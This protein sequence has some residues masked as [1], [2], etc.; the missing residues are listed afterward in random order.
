[1]AA[2]KQDL[3]TVQFGGKTYTMRTED[4]WTP[5]EAVEVRDYSD[6]FQ[7]Q[8]AEAQIEVGATDEQ[9]LGTKAL[10]NMARQAKEDGSYRSIIALG[11]WPVTGKGTP[12]AYSADAAAKHAEEIESAD[13]GRSEL[14]PALALALRSFI[15]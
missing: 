15:S 4:Q 14:V 5:E 11:L 3:P 13:Y 9:R 2:K 6:E 12:L 8:T 7:F 1:M 10:I